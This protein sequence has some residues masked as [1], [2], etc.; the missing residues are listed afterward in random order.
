MFS[1]MNQGNLVLSNLP[2]SFQ[3][4]VGF[5]AGQYVKHW[6]TFVVDVIGEDGLIGFVNRPRPYPDAVLE[7][8]EN[9]ASW[10]DFKNIL[11]RYIVERRKFALVMP[12]MQAEMNKVIHRVYEGTDVPPLDVKNML[13]KRYTALMHSQLLSDPATMDAL[14]RVT[15]QFISNAL[16]E[17]FDLH[18]KLTEQ[19]LDIE[20]VPESQLETWWEENTVEGECVYDLEPYHLLGT[21]SPFLW[22]TP[23]FLQWV[24]T[25]EAR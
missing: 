25:Q 9:P 22:P 3:N 14:G 5:R 15:D 21:L 2:T 19:T 23:E 17:S 8:M 6:R 1:L 13:R 16:K 24:T 18:V 7:R 11:N 20:L 4:E 10:A 12:H